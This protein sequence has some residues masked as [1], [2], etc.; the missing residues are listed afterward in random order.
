M[1]LQ[2]ASYDQNSYA[3]QSFRI[4][5]AITA[6]AACLP[7]WLIKAMGRWSSDAYQS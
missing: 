4:G 1:L 2:L 5:T 3:S 7:T 6:A